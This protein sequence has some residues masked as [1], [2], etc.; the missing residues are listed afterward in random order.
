[1]NLWHQKL[2][3]TKKMIKIG[4]TFAWKTGVYLR[5]ANKQIIKKKG[6]KPIQTHFPINPIHVGP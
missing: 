2:E 3:K 5:K 4:M 1:M 6:Q